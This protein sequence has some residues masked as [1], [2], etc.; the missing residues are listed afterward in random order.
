MRNIGRIEIFTDVP[1]IN[2]ANIIEVLRNAF[3]QHQQNVTKYNFLLNYEAGEQ[4]L[5]RTKKYRSDIN[6]KCVDNIANEVTEFNLGFKWGHPITLVQRGDSDTV[7]NL[8]R[9]LNNFYEDQ[10]IRAK[11]QKLG[12]FVE[13]CGVGYTY[14]DI[15]SEDAP[16]L[17]ESLDPRFTFVVRSSYYIDRRVMLG[18]TYRRASNGSNYFT[19]FTKDRRYEVENTHEVLNGNVVSKNPEK[20]GQIERSGEE[21]P[22]GVVPIVEWIRSYDRMGCFERQISEMDNL[23]LLISDFTNDVEQNTQCV[24]HANDT[25]FPKEV[26]ENEDGNKVET[27]KSPQ[28]GQWLVTQTTMDGKTPFVKPLAVDYDYSG[29]LN[30]IITRRSLI[31]Q[32][33]NVPQRNDNSGGS[34]GVAMSDATGWSAA[35]SSA[36]K[37]QNIMESCKMQEV[38]IVLRAIKKSSMDGVEDLT[39]LK[40]TDIQPSIKR[41][42]TYELTVKTNAISTLIAHGFA[43]EDAISV[44]PLFEDPAQTIIRSRDGVR[45]YQETSVF[46]ENKQSGDEK[47]PFADLSD[48]ENN[49]PVIGK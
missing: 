11:Q 30:N 21:N 49:S 47:R 5:K 23:N 19:C 31:L 6:C 35:E 8:V 40:K 7:A 37:Q 1:E 29:M 25:E 13:I 44:A 27:T 43:L 36:S 39:E 24:W 38:A 2:S 16:F 10:E 17:I 3:A 22:L 33:C 14:V 28:S 26:V 12:R 41:Q 15:N 18:V 9:K 34:T 4:P 20:W 42:K 48:Q 45:K 32:K 46:G